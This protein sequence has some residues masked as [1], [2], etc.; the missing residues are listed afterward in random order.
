MQIVDDHKINLQK[1]ENTFHLFEFGNLIIRQC[2][3]INHAIHHLFYMFS[4]HN[5]LDENYINIS[6]DGFFSI[7][8]QSI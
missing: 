8:A 7:I 6:M 5:I 2:V 3:S 4:I 1:Y